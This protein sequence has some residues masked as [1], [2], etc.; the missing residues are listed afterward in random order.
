MSC[1]AS[2]LEQT[3]DEQVGEEATVF[4]ASGLG[5]VLSLT[6]PLASLR[7][8]RSVGD[9]ALCLHKVSANVS[10]ALADMDMVCGWSL[11]VCGCG[12]AGI[13]M[14]GQGITQRQDGQQ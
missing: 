12:I 8:S 1:K 10:P 11:C 9:L 14:W 3:L 13:E 7:A 2:V 4:P 6:F 5:Q